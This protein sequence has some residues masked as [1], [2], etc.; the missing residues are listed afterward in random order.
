M[1][2]AAAG[3]HSLALRSDG[4]LVAWGGNTYAQTNPPTGLDHVARISAGENRNLVLPLR[5]QI[6]DISCNGANA[7][8]RFHTFAGYQYEV[9]T[10][11]NLAT[12]P[13]NWTPL[14]GSSLGG[15]GRTESVADTNALTKTGIQFYRLKETH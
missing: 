3:S 15:T 8:I 13:P 14:A 5:V 4:T 9:E 7:V 12:L 6:E 2:I 1:G 10:S 11:T